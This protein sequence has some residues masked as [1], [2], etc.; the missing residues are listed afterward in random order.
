MIDRIDSRVCKTIYLIATVLGEPIYSNLGFE[1]ET[2]Y[3]FYKDLPLNQNNIVSANIVPY[4]KTHYDQIRI[5]D[6]KISRENRMFH[7]DNYLHNAYVFTRN[8]HVE[9]Y[10]MPDFYEG[11]VVATSPEAGTTLMKKRFL[12]KE[13][14]VFPIDNL[15]AMACISIQGLEPFKIAK[16]MRLGEIR[17]VDFTKIYNR[18]AGSIG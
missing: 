7:F 3:L 12:S 17:D 10:Y 11:M 18:I 4:D 15:E 8:N 1:T 14:A 16:R 9:G 2:E 5:I 6:E 13:H